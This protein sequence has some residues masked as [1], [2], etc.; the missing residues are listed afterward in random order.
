MT[1][2]TNQFLKTGMSVHDLIDISD[3]G[4]ALMTAADAQN[5]ASILEVNGAMPVAGKVA[6]RADLPP[7]PAAHRGERYL[8]E[9]DETS[10]GQSVYYD[11]DGTAWNYAGVVP[12]A[13]KSAYELAVEHGFVGTEAEWL[14]SLTGSTVVRSF[15]KAGTL[16]ERS[17]F[18]GRA[19]GFAYLVTDAVPTA[20][21]VR[22]DTAGDGWRGPIA[23]QGPTGPEGPQGDHGPAGPKGDKGD[24][25]VAGPAGPQGP[26]GANA[27]PVCTTHIYI[28]AAVDPGTPTGGS[29]DMG[30]RPP[31]VTPPAGW[32]AMPVATDGNPEWVSTVVVQGSTVVSSPSWS[33]AVKSREDGAAGPNDGGSAP[34][35]VCQLLLNGAATAALTA[36]PALGA[37][38]WTGQG[39]LLGETTT[40]AANLA[41]DLSTTIRRLDGAKY[42]DATP[43]N[44]ADGVPFAYDTGGG[45]SDHGLQLFEKGAP[46]ADGT[47]V[48][49]F[50]LS[51]AATAAG[52]IYPDEPGDGDLG[53]QTLDG[54]NFGVDG[55]WRAITCVLRTSD[56]DSLDEDANFVNSA[57]AAPTSPAY[58][59]IVNPTA[60][61]SDQ[62]GAVEQFNGAY[63]AATLIATVTDTGTTNAAGEA[64]YFVKLEATGLG[65]NEV[66]LWVQCP[67]AGVEAWAKPAYGAVGGL[68]V[69]GVIDTSWS[70]DH[71]DL[72]AIGAGA[73]MTFSRPALSHVPAA[74][75][76]KPLRV[77]LVAAL[78]SAGSGSAEMLVE[79]VNPNAG[80]V[81]MFWSAGGT[82]ELIQANTAT[83]TPDISAYDDGMAHEVT[84][85][86]GDSDIELWIDGNEIA[87]SFDQALDLTSFE[88]SAIHF[89]N[90]AAGNQKLQGEIVRAAV[91]PERGVA[92][93]GED[94]RLW[95]RETIMLS[96]A[97]YDAL[98]A[99]VVGWLYMIEEAS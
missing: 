27:D 67:L 37:G 89:G 41:I 54:D 75:I 65:A 32:S 63:T 58:L 43:T 84:L 46:G 4:R 59:V 90:N 31:T 1:M 51:F 81:R 57:V 45:L 72:P 94:V 76:V 49:G 28:R 29:I 50:Y 30:A 42:I 12:K 44:T 97:E 83:A 2:S 34:P 82:F 98:L 88:A 96:Q 40:W 23:Y 10:G 21:Y 6:T 79:I 11:C 92:D 87:L 61:T 20:V 68:S 86:V 66:A 99:P 60:S 71:P 53:I 33:A 18:N 77:S 74:N 22:D 7:D 17:A 62:A 3:T 13:G 9:A 19:E 25:G 36:S 91:S 93:P 24:A 47:M 8:V 48:W 39:G 69:G 35:P 26:P 55:A 64:V 15:D 85:I 73:S 52:G 95:P 5:A 56:H 80:D 78:A 70:Y 38:D 14:A 16:A